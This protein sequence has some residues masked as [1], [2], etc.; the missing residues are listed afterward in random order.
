MSLFEETLVVFEMADPSAAKELVTET[1]VVGVTES[2]VIR[3]RSV[4]VSINFQITMLD[5]LYVVM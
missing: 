1:T 5:R 4:K 3:K 2:G